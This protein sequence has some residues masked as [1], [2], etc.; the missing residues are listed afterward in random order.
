MAEMWTVAVT[1][2][3]H[4]KQQEE[5][6]KEAAARK[7][8][9][10]VAADAKGAGEPASKKGSAA[11]AAQRADLVT[12]RDGTPV[13]DAA[14]LQLKAGAALPEPSLQEYERVRATYSPPLIPL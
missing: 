13:R 1:A 5:A 6:R 4:A 3:L 2:E 12:E 14:D 8:P 11:R 9:Q 10:D 7:A